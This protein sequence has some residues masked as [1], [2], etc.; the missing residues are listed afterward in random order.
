MKK[1]IFYCLIFSFLI[2]FSLVS[3]AGI[4]ETADTAGNAKPTVA[5]LFVNNATTTYD[6]ELT[7]R[8]MDNF[9]ALLKNKYVIIPGARYIDLLHKAGISDITTA[10]RGD[11]MEVFKGENID[12]VLYAELQPF[13]RKER[14][15]FFTQG[16]D[17]TAVV[18]VKIIGLKENKYLYNGKFTEFSRDSTSFGMV[19]NKSVALAALDKVIEKMNPLILERLLESKAKLK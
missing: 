10:E 18:P 9:D 14:Y 1:R 5:L 7:A 6:P 3:A 4:T 11:I 19:G 13:L 2:S 8:M 12:F 17:M 15:T 16:I